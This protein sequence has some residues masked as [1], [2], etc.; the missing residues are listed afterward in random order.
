MNS[1]K[2]QFLFVC[3][4]FLFGYNCSVTAVTDEELEALEKQLEQQETELIKQ[5]ELKEKNKKAEAEVK[6][7]A[8]QQRKAKAKA[9]KKRLAEIEKKKK[10]DKLKILKAKQCAPRILKPNPSA[11]PDISPDIY[12]N[13][14]FQNVPAPK[15]KQGKYVIKH[16]K[17]SSD[18]TYRTRTEAISTYQNLD[19]VAQHVAYNSIYETDF[20]NHSDSA[21]NSQSKIISDSEFQSILGGFVL[22]KNVSET[23][24]ESDGSKGYYTSETEDISA[25]G[26][27]FPLKKGNTLELSYIENT[28]F[29][30]SGVDT[31]S[32]HINNVKYHVED[33][34]DAESLNIGLTCKVFVI[35]SEKEF[36][37]KSLDYDSTNT[38]FIKNKMHFSEQLGVMISDTTIDAD[39]TQT[40][41]LVD[42]ELLPAFDIEKFKQNVD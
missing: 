13:P 37:I 20:I 6:R 8:E 40:N 22:L 3:L 35:T 21:Y 15:I 10:E 38:V 11:F 9:E 32:Q 25:Q 24:T 41:E 34:I 19:N 5:K 4:M 30:S 1:N 16:T 14:V 39:Y 31:R 12:N 7:K 28:H 27:L 26:Q 18:N 17:E 36:T 29:K 23:T 42:Y 2:S 33:V